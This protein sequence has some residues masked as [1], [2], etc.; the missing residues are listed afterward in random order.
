MPVSFI[1]LTGLGKNSPA[2]QTSSVTPG[3]QKCDRA[4]SHERIGIQA[5]DL[6]CF[7]ALL[8]VVQNGKAQP[9]SLC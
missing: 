3:Y 5:A 1:G 8:K 4:G 9:K 6:C 7:D 2:E